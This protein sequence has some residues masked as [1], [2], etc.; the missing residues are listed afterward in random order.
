MVLFTPTFTNYSLVGEGYLILGLM[1]TSPSRVACTSSFLIN[2]MSPSMPVEKKV[3]RPRV[4]SRPVL[5]K[6]SSQAKAKSSEVTALTPTRGILRVRWNHALGDAA[7]G[8]TV[9]AAI[10][11]V[12]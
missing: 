3:I 1:I 5:G 6:T 7:V 9:I 4:G 2:A 8:A 11:T 12:R 10:R